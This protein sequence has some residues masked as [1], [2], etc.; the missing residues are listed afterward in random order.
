MTAIRD[1]V[2]GEHGA[3]GGH[4]KQLAELGVAG[5]LV[6]E[7][8]GGS[9]LGMLDAVVAAEV[10]GWG[11]APGP[12]L[13]T[14]VLAPVALQAGGSPE[15]QARWLPPIATG[16]SRMGAAVTELVSRRDDA[17]VETRDGRLVGRALMV[18]DAHGGRS[19]SGCGRRRS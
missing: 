1:L 16:A 13:A 8:W 10:L 3:D 17:G 9:G 19:L 4:W 5:L 15:Q 2:D 18:L 11:V 12:F 6:P 14:A 7:Q